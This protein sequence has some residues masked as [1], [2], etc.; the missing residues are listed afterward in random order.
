MTHRCAALGPGAAIPCAMVASAAR[1][2]V[3]DRAPGGGAGKMADAGRRARGAG[4]GAQGPG[5]G[6]GGAQ[7]AGLGPQGPIPFSLVVRLWYVLGFQRAILPIQ[8]EGKSHEKRGFL[9]GAKPD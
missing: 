5:E 3:G 8:L 6:E 9:P 1:I 7:G 2:A 4:P